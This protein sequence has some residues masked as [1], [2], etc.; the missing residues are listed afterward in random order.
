MAKRR[1][2]VRETYLRD[3]ILLQET[4]RRGVDV[5]RKYPETNAKDTDFEHAVEKARLFCIHYRNITAS[6][7]DCLP[8]R[9]QS[10]QKTNPYDSI[11][12]PEQ[13]QESRGISISV[14]NQVKRRPDQV[15][16]AFNELHN[17]AK[18][19]SAEYEILHGVDIRAIAR[20]KTLEEEGYGTA[21]ESLIDLLTR[22]DTNLD[23]EKK[24]AALQRDYL[25]IRP[26]ELVAFRFGPAFVRP[27]E[28]TEPMDKYTYELCQKIYDREHERIRNVLDPRKNP[29]IG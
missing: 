8:A 25:L 18:A 3:L 20:L 21:S 14:M 2:Y 11:G 16:S 28:A 6:L 23:P 26:I 13:P 12:K 17:G 10:V 1:L 5:T 27:A 9:K 22:L 29:V 4:A 7:N 19:R 24:N 15:V